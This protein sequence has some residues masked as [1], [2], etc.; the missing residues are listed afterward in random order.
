MVGTHRYS[1]ITLPQLLAA[2]DQVESG[3]D[4]DAVGDNG[5]AI[6]ID[7][8]HYGYW[9]DTPIAGRWEDCFDKEYSHRVVVSYFNMYGW[10]YLR[11]GNMMR[12]AM[13][14]H[15]GPSG[16]WRKDDPDHYVDKIKKALKEEIK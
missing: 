15:Y 9:D 14:H 5:H 13:I 10:G 2:I 6:G 7:Q 4:P 1:D 8:I 16:A 12:L 11:A 3:G